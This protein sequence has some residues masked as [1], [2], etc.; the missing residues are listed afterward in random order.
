MLESAYTTNKWRVTYRLG[1]FSLTEPQTMIPYLECLVHKS[2][3]NISTVYRF[4]INSN[5][6]TPETVSYQAIDQPNG[7]ERH[8]CER[9]TTSQALLQLI[10]ITSLGR[11]KM[12]PNISI[13]STEIVM[14]LENPKNHL[15]RKFSHRKSRIPCEYSTNRLSQPDY[16][17]SSVRAPS[18]AMPQS[19]ARGPSQSRPFGPDESVRNESR[20]RNHGPVF[21]PDQRNSQNR[22]GRKPVG[23][24]GTFSS[25]AAHW[26]SES[27]HSGGTAV[28][29]SRTRTVTEP[30][31]SLSTMSVRTGEQR[32]M[33][34]EERGEKLD[35]VL[36]T[37]FE[38][39]KQ[40]YRYSEPTRSSG[41]LSE[42]YE[43]PASQ[44]PPGERPTN[45]SVDPGR[46]EMLSRRATSEE[47][48]WNQSYTA[49]QGNARRLTSDGL[50]RDDPSQEIMVDA[51]LRSD[52]EVILNELEG[53][54]SQ[55]SREISDAAVSPEMM[56]RQVIRQNE[57][58]SPKLR[59]LRKGLEMY[60]RMLQEAKEIGRGWR[61]KGLAYEKDYG[62]KSAQ[63][64]DMNQYINKLH[65]DLNKLETNYRRVKGTNDELRRVRDDQNRE[66]Q[67][68]EQMRDHAVRQTRGQERREWSNKLQE[69]K[70]QYRIEIQEAR[71]QAE[72]AETDM[73]QQ[74]GEWDR[75][76]Q[77]YDAD[78]KALQKQISALE[79]T[80]ETEKQQMR[81]RFLEEKEKMEAHFRE[82][83]GRVKI[84]YQIKNEQLKSER[85]NREHIK[86]L[87]DP[88][89]ATIFEDFL[90]LIEN[91]SLNEWDP[92]TEDD[93]PISEHTLQKL[94]EGSPMT[95]ELKELI[96]Q[97]YL[98]AIMY[99]RVFATPYQ[100]F[101]DEG[102]RRFQEWTDLYGTGKTI[103]L[104]NEHRGLR[105]DRQIL[106]AG[107][108]VA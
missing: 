59:D 18:N 108:P 92:N 7:Y 71:Y 37:D 15:P 91:I 73:M 23:S 88:E 26:N 105:V 11:W 43:L 32:P 27:Y 5:S 93:W 12:L 99:H 62:A 96:V 81:L 95:S 21:H 101:G 6:R 41:L 51:Y 2:P 94:L 63:I 16:H 102:E 47:G 104:E 45:A 34:D 53:A 86:G 38:Q 28:T 103:N 49:S 90:I 31:K 50:R 52:M 22:K 100:V 33:V 40:N 8:H 30:S 79:I 42:V 64:E 46:S 17:R 83:K 80:H 20:A 84:R 48:G 35:D 89:L 25:S 13:I 97:S 107:L 29:E 44:D 58:I 85:V 56:R 55:T 68:M 14:I 36:G 1:F 74:Q 66:L 77:Q 3:S 39:R 69:A 67:A 106:Q 24:Q 10:Y 19:R 54:L 76:V 78:R 61:A 87:T 72:K 70:Q 60:S 75:K 65:G 82:Q 4:S 98:W 9:R 57:V